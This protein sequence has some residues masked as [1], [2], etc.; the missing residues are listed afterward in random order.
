[1]QTVERADL[2]IEPRWV[3]PIAPRRAALAR[4]AVAVVRGRIAAVGPSAQLAARFDPLERIELP[5]HAL[6]PGF[7]NAHTCVGRLLFRGRGDPARPRDALGAASRALAARGVADGAPPAGRELEMSAELVHDGAQLAA[8]EMLRS[9][10]TTFGSRGAYPEEVARV[11][12]G[13]RVRAVIGLPVTERATDW[14]QGVTG[15]LA[16]AER[17]WDEHKADPWV[18]LHFAPEASHGLSD[19]AL[20]RVRTVADELDARISMP[21]HESAEQIEHH[22]ARHAVRPLRRLD[23]LGLLSP[24]LTALYLNHLDEAEL[25][26]VAAKGVVV[27]ACLQSSLRRGLG[28]APLAALL[29]RGV[30]IGL[31]TGSPA[32]AFALD[33]L[34]E[35]RAASLAAS[36]RHGE[37]EA[38]DA[39]RALELATLGGAAALGVKATVGSIEPGKAADLVA[40]D[41]GSFMMRPA[42]DPAEVIVFAAGRER[43]SHVWINGTPRVA[44]GRL[45]AFDEAELVEIAR[46]WEERL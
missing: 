19:A 38:I 40:L 1:M 44:E 7:V 37:P 28:C 36:C 22:V 15:H 10:V 18:C 26:L 33:L 12:A 8:A 11:A 31:G 41:L 39:H 9:G 32:A 30:D 45:L 46:R 20:A 24:A 21:V 25:E 5:N 14:A 42:Q 34:A 43:I 17:L 27:A 23:A 13:A 2:L 16:R 29:Q 3:L 4:H 6:L 35:S